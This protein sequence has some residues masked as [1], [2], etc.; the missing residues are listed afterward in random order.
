MIHRDGAVDWDRLADHLGGALAGTPEEA[1]V[2][3][4]VATDPSWSRAAAE[5]SEAL[6]AVVADLHAF[7]APPALPDDVAARLDTA[8]RAAGDSLASDEAPAEAAGAAGAGAVP[9]PRAGAPAPDHATTAGSRRSPEGSRRPPGHADAEPRH[10]A[11]GPRRPG[12]RPRRRR[13]ARWGGGL[14]LAAG[15]AAFAAIGISSLLPSSPTPFAGGGNDSGDAGAPEQT[16]TA[17]QSR[18]GAAE[19]PAIVATG[20]EYQRP[21]VGASEPQLPADGPLGTGTPE[22]G[23]AQGERPMAEPP[24]GTTGTE[25]VPDVVPPTL[26]GMWVDPA[27]RKQC[28]DLIRAAL[29]PPPV[30]VDTVDFAQ[31][32]GQDAIVVW[33]TATDGT[34]VVWVSGPGCGTTGAGTDQIYQDQLS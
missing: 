30:T 33:A 32:D 2:A 26:A 17:D 15:A 6:A 34:R 31:F 4:L 22:I 11:T 21:T 16:A 29:G 14:A 7:P 5:L 9:G 13:L 27:A 28:L 18:V 20:T 3:N 24:E 25:R 12:G 19:L 10:R 1:E 23:P 8:L